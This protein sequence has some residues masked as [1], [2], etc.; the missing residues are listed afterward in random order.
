MQ[1]IGKKCYSKTDG[2][3]FCNARKKILI[4]ND[5]KLR[6]PTIFIMVITLSSLW[7]LSFLFGKVLLR[8]LEPIQ[9]LASRWTISAL[10]FAAL[11]LAGKL[12]IDFHKKRLPFLVAAALIEP[13][14]YSLCEMYG[15]DMTSASVSSIFI[16]T[17]PLAVLL[18]QL[19]FFHRRPTVLSVISI[20]TAFGGVLICT[21]FSPQFSISGDMT[22]YVVLA[23][24]VA[25][26][27][28]YAGVS[29]KAGE[30]YSP[31]EITAVMSFSGALW[32]DALNFIMGYGTATVTSYAGKPG[33]IACVLILGLLC[34][35]ACYIMFNRLL[36]SMNPAIANS[37]VANSVTAVGVISGIFILDDPAG[38]YTAIGL[39]LTIGGVLLS[40]KDMQSS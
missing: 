5:R 27:A 36:S 17:I 37:I 33:M 1:T 16:A 14:T 26:G 28:A 18:S 8:E 32:F 11:M 7:G 22:G 4:M 30:D 24:T 2:L 38:L 31:F 25:T 20:C 6:K 21:V 15:L 13:C 34:S 39:V 29:A 35:S 40:S 23:G 9:V 10:F 12:R 19:L 3:T